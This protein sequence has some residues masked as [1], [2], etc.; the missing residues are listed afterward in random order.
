MLTNNE[1]NSSINYNGKNNEK[2]ENISIK[3]ADNDFTSDDS[4]EEK[5]GCRIEKLK[6]NNEIAFNRSEDDNKANIS[7]TA[8]NSS[9]D[10]E[11]PIQTKESFNE[12][13]ISLQTY[14]TILLA[15]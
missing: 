3:D 15:V 12:S 8:S 2:E 9:D 1:N 5:E 14:F 10:E 7:C 6:E 13:G 11:K 4:T